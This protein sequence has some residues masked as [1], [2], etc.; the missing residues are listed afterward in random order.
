MISRINATLFCLNDITNDG[1]VKTKVKS[2][3]E[4]MSKVTNN[5][6][7]YRVGYCFWITRIMITLCIVSA[8][9]AFSQTEISFYV[10][11]FHLGIA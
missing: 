10:L 6:I 11:R 2:F 5:L 7:F 9:V 4:N 3:R 8:A 1:R